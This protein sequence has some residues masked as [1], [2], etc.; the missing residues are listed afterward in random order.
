MMGKGPVKLIR[1]H[2]LRCAGTAATVRE[3]SRGP[4]A[5]HPCALHPFRFGKNPRRR[6]CGPSLSSES[7]KILRGRR[8]NGLP[9]E[10]V[11][12]QVVDS[13][14]I[15]SG[16][17]EGTGKSGSPVLRDSRVPTHIRPLSPAEVMAAVLLRGVQWSGKRL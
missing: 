11:T 13:E 2:C 16:Q 1:L 8:G 5:E 10:K 14:T 12:S 7:A 9:C 6:G 17:R 4:G 3:C 15:S